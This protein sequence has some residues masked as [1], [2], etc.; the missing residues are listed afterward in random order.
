MG[1]RHRAVR[2]A[3]DRR[4]N[5]RRR[6]GRPRGG[7]GTPADQSSIRRSCAPFSHWSV[8][9]YPPPRR[10]VTSASADQPST[11]SSR[12]YPAHCPSSLAGIME[13]RTSE[14]QVGELVEAVQGLLHAL[15][16]KTPEPLVLDFTAGSSDTSRTTS[17]IRRPQL[18]IELLLN[19]ALAECAG[20]S[21][22]S[23]PRGRLRRPLAGFA[24]FQ[25][26]RGASARR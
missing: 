24:A 10:L 25:L 1:W 7:A 21:P 9:G 13:Q 15:A 18:P 26:P 20:I 12:S 19:R 11:A 4:A 16:G 2:T 23:W 17:D 14:P 8:M 5:P 22:G 3:P 6:G